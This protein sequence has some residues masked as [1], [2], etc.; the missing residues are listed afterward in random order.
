MA[1]AENPDIFLK[2]FGVPCVFAAR[3]FQGIFDKPDEMMNMAGV[4]VLSTM[5]VCI[6]KTSDVVASVIKSGTTG[7]VGGVSY[8]VRDVLMLDD[9]TFTQLTLSF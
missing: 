4:N 5:Y 2:E 8:A 1:F 7:T 9:G 6:V 3:T